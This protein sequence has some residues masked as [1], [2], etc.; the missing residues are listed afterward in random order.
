MCLWI[1][2]WNFIASPL[3]GLKTANQTLRGYLIV[4]G[5]LSPLSPFR[6]VWGPMNC[7]RKKGRE[8]RRILGTADSVQWQPWLTIKGFSNCKACRTECVGPTQSA[9]HELLISEWRL[10]CY[11]DCQLS[12]ARPFSPPVIG[13]FCSCVLRAQWKSQNKE[14]GVNWGNSSSHSILSNVSKLSGG[15]KLK[16]MRKSRLGSTGQTLSW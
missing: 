6:S 7:S 13:S 3:L 11:T 5:L 16:K 1:Y 4:L 9:C 2:C 10:A 14:F 12:E 8:N 15:W